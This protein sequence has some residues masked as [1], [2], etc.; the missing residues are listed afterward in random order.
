MKTVRI[1]VPK[2]DSDLASNVIGLFAL[3]AVIVAIGGLTHNWWWSLLA[4]G[5]FGV[6]IAFML[7][8][9]DDIEEVKE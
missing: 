8:L 3:L 2:I 7:G 5:I 9:P 4:T 1:P 6:G